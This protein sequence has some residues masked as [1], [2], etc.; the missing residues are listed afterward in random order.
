MCV[1][2]PL[3]RYRHRYRPVEGRWA[4]GRP[5]RGH[6]TSTEAER[7]LAALPRGRADRDGRSDGCVRRCCAVVGR[8][9]GLLVSVQ[10]N[11]S[12]HLVTAVAGELSIFR[13]GV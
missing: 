12:L 1:R 4:A 9:V 7:G 6:V 10:Y 3:P 5:D 11:T 8:R 2:V 13:T